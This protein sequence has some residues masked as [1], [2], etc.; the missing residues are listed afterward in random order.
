MNEINLDE[1]DLLTLDMSAVKKG[2]TPWKPLYSFFTPKEI[3]E[4]AQEIAIQE[5]INQ[6]IIFE[7]LHYSLMASVGCYRTA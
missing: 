2:N 7:A 1:I 5:I 6:Q 4:R 3:N